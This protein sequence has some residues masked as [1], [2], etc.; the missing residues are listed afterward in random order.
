M[1]RFHVYDHYYNY[2]TVDVSWILNVYERVSVCLVPT[3]ERWNLRVNR[4]NA[5]QTR[6][7]GRGPTAD[8]RLCCPVMRH[9]TKMADF[10]CQPGSTCQP[11]S[12]AGGRRLSRDWKSGKRKKEKT[13]L[14]TDCFFVF[15]LF[16]QT[17]TSS[18]REK[19]AVFPQSR[20]PVQLRT[21]TWSTLT[22]YGIFLPKKKK[23]NPH[24]TGHKATR[25]FR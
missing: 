6:V 25:A 10:A 20:A 24:Q 16:T 18:F 3:P 17:H 15:C 13:L 4:S 12:L 19:H 21:T 1:S 7:C 5:S 23:K 2:V 9:F 8:T 14:R 22:G 11:S